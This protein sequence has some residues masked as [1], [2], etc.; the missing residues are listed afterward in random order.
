MARIISYQMDK[1]IQGKTMNTLFTIVIP[2]YNRCK[3]TERAI[4]SVKQQSYENWQLIVVD[5]GSTDDTWTYLKS[6][7]DERISCLHKDNG[8]ECS[9]RNHALAHIKGDYVCYLDS[10]DTL[11]N[12][13]LEVF[14]RII[15]NSTP[16]SIICAGVGVKNEDLQVINQITPKVNKGEIID[17]YLRGSFNLMPFC[18]PYSIAISKKFDPEYYYGGDFEYLL[19]LLIRCNIVSSQNITSY[20]HEHG[21]RIVRNVFKAPI[22][23]YKQMEDS[24]IKTILKNKHELTEFL[25]SEI[26]EE[27]IAEKQNSFILATANYN[28]TKA[29]DLQN[30]INP[31]KP[32][33]LFTLR[34]Q[35]FK[36]IIKSIIGKS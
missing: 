7:K 28:L 16:D 17:Q 30:Y 1:N 19:S 27:A 8:G 24:V 9:A 22:K 31:K 32:L 2:T 15:A 13:Y 35:R 10:D 36:G 11:A 34:T 18:L 33:S 5:D 29:I 21:G 4:Q 12:N 3:L 20:V 26:I 23:G 14:N 6:I 25:S